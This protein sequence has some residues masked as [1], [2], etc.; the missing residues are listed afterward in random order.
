MQTFLGQDFFAHL[1]FDCAISKLIVH[2][3][4]SAAITLF[5]FCVVSAPFLSSRSFAELIA[6]SYLLGVFICFVSFMQR[7]TFSVK[8]L[9]IPL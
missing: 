1:R 7:P 6:S 5:L 9:F 2:L 4:E 8:Y 3:W